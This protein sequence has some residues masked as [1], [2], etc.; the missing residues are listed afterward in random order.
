MLAIIPHLSIDIKLKNKKMK[1]DKN[2]MRTKKYIFTKIKE[3][4]K[5]PKI[6]PKHVE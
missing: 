1:S 3:R 4:T 5:T 2:P 6:R